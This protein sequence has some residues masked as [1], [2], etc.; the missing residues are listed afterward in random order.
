MRAIVI[1]FRHEDIGEAVQ[2]AAVGRVWLGKFLGGGDAVLLQHDQ[3]QFRFHNRTG[4][5][6][7]HTEN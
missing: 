6:Q 5:E 2:V 1:G 7:F 4:E 3:E